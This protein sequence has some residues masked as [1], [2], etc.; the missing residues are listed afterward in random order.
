MTYRSHH[1]LSRVLLCSLFIIL[2]TIHCC[3]LYVVC[4]SL[5]NN[6][7]HSRARSLQCNHPCNPAG[8]FILLFNPFF[9]FHVFICGLIPHVMHDISLSIVDFSFCR[10]PTQQPTNQPTRQPT[11]QPSSQPTMVPSRQPTRFHFSSHFISHTP[12]FRFVP[13]LLCYPFPHP[14]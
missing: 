2:V 11:Q 1:S 6:P 13:T 8:N 14:F 7:P 10:Q 3:V 12:L 4:C 5:R 9:V